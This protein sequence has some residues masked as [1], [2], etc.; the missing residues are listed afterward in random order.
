[1]EWEE[2]RSAFARD[3]SYRDLYVLGTTAEDWRLL[4]S[5]LKGSEYGLRFR[6]GDDWGSVPDAPDGLFAGESGRTTLLSVDVG[7]VTVNAHFF[8]ADQIE[9]DLVPNEVQT[10]ERGASLFR[11][12]RGIGLALGKPVRLTPENDRDYVLIEYDPKRD[13]LQKGREYGGWW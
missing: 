4:L 3:G 9:L 11:F 5:F 12:M 10:A 6:H 7:G 1:M 8:E 2:A 13:G